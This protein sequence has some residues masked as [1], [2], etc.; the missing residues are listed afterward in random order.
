MARCKELSNSQ[1]P[2][3]VQLG[4]DR[5]SYRNISSNL[6]IPF[7]TINSFIARFKRRNILENKKRTGAPRKISPT[8]SRKLGRLLNQNPMVTREE[9]QEDLRSSGCSLLW[10][11]ITKFEL[12]GHNHR[13]H[14]W[15]K[16]GEAYSP[17]N[18]VPTVKFGG[19]SM[20]IWGC[21]SAKGL[22]KI[23]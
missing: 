10:T 17:K 7:T 21:F 4:K 20:M 22:G 15:R 8:L 12:F 18:T 1:K 16:D 6:N 3:I 5:E 14:L 13:N 2:L 11:I 23:L 9:Q 19:G